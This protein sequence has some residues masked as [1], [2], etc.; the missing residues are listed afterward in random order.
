M[1]HWNAERRSHS[2]CEERAGRGLG[3]G[4]IQQKRDSSPRPSPPPP[5]EEREKSA[6]DSPN[7]RAVGH[8]PVPPGDSPG[9][10]ETAPRANKDGP[11]AKRR[12]ALPFGESPTGTGG[13]P[14]LPFFRTRS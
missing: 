8:W 3:R 1:K 5:S 6:V 13:S 2:P 9:G 10:T 4:E 11:F 14:V 12:R 7:S